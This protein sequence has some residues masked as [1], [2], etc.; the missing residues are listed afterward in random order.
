M[1][2]GDKLRSVTVGRV[3]FQQQFSGFFIQGRLRIRVNEE[4]LDSDQ[5]MSDAVS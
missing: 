1:N 2:A 3:V 4:A 5:N